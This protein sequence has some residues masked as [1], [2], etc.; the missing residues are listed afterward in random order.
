MFNGFRLK[1]IH[2]KGSSASLYPVRCR[3][4]VHN[5]VVLALSPAPPRRFTRAQSGSTDGWLPECRAL[6]N[7]DKSLAVAARALVLVGNL[8]GVKLALCGE[9]S[10]VSVYH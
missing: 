8:L 3:I 2:S 5:Y 7:F 6:F 9:F 4:S 10:E 1:T